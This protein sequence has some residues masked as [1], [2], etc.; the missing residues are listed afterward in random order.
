MAEVAKLF[1]DSGVICLS[2]FISPFKDDR[3]N[4][5]SIHLKDN[6]RFFECYLDVPLDVCESRDAKGLYK[7]AR[8]GLIKGFTGIDQ[9][10][11][12]P[13]NPD[14]V[15]KTAELDVEQ[16]IQTVITF[17]IENDI[18]EPET[19]EPIELFVPENKKQILIEEAA[20]LESIE[21]DKI[22]LQWLQVLSEG[23]ATPLRGFMREKEYLR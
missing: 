1:A 8:E 11:E 13:D 19:I 7:K 4:A 5:K 9:P 20:S 18:I 10:Y 12:I 6:L 22:S 3:V 16:C 21:L 14:L 2:S 23:W 17:L 15:L